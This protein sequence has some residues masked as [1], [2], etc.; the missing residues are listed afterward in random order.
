M[1][2]RLK[3]MILILQRI[4]RVPSR[5]DIP[6]VREPVTN[7]NHAPI[8]QAQNGGSSANSQEIPVTVDNVCPDGN[9]NQYVTS[10]SGESLGR[11]VNVRRSERI[12]NF[13]QRFTPDLGPLESGRMTM[14]Q[15][16]ILGYIAV[17]DF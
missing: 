17:G 16:Q 15:P 8:V 7:G 13:P 12:R 4:W 6:S 10:P 11:N 9:E 14:L 1:L 5:T 3:A 2:S